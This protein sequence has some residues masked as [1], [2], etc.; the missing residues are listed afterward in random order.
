[1]WMTWEYKKVWGQ[2]CNSW[3]RR[4]LLMAGF[5]AFMLQHVVGKSFV[6]IFSELIDRIDVVSSVWP[7][8]IFKLLGV[9][10]A[11][12]GDANATKSHLPFHI[13]SGCWCCWIVWLQ[14][15]RFIEWQNLATFTRFFLYYTH[16]SFFFLVRP[17]HLPLRPFLLFFY[18]FDETKYFLCLFTTRHKFH[19]CFLSL[20]LLILGLV[21]FMLLFKRL[22]SDFFAVYQIVYQFAGPFKS[23]CLYLTHF[24]KQR[25]Y[26][27]SIFNSLCTMA[28]E[29][30][31]TLVC[32]LDSKVPIDLSALTKIQSSCCY[33]SVTLFIYLAHMMEKENNFIEFRVW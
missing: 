31:N 27:P 30:N 6:D 16:R 24:L 19:T 18:S 11:V 4:P 2:T 32:W 21:Q 25:W 26:Q 7:L 29:P 10:N 12:A 5:V 3:N 14:L 8:R 13:F 20:D 9:C 33:Y 28:I 15:Q 23:I 17:S 22:K 1:M